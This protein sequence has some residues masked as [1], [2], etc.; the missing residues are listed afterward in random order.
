MKKYVAK[1]I[2]KLARYAS[3]KVGKQGTDL[4]GQIARKIDPLYFKKVSK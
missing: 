3:R 4:P 2:A 1:N